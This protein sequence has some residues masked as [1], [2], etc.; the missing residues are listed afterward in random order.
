MWIQEFKDLS[1]V[2]LTKAPAETL[3][4]AEK[5]DSEGNVLNLKFNG[6]ELFAKVTSSTS[7]QI[8]R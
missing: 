6:I 4:T 2:T 5:T 1:V 7:G 8:V 3:W